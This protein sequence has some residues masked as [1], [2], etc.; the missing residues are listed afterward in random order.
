MRDHSEKFERAG[1]NVVLVGLGDQK[2]SEDFKKE[3]KFS[4]PL[5]CDKEMKLYKS[6]SVKRASYMEML[7]PGL[8]FKGLKTMAQGNK[9]STPKGDPLQ[10]G[11][12]C[13]IDTQGTIR[14][15]YQSKDAADNPSVELILDS[16]R[17]LKLTKAWKQEG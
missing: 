15:N 9:L 12:V 5:I 16:A 17:E 3:M 8:I 14:W 6:F 7:S 4:F 13:L 10:L 2:L 1:I 11:G